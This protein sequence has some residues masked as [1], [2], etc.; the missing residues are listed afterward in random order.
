M[1]VR[2]ELI[3]F[4]DMPGNRVHVIDVQKGKVDVLLKTL[5]LMEPKSPFYVRAKSLAFKNSKRA[6]LARRLRG[7][8][9]WQLDE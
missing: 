5:S 1:L 7:R 6:V 2:D 8:S 4:S 9:R 3:F